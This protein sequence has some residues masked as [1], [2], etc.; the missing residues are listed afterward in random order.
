MT[1]EMLFN[2][3]I[4][5]SAAGVVLSN[6]RGDIT[7]IE[8]KASSATTQKKA[9]QLSIPFETAKVHEGGIQ[10]LFHDTVLGTMA[11]MVDDETVQRESGKFHLVTGKLHIFN[12]TP[13]LTVGRIFVLFRGDP[14]CQL[15]PTTTDETTNPQWMNPEE[16]LSSGHPIRPFA[17]QLLEHLIHEDTLEQVMTLP[18]HPLFPRGFSIERFYE[19]RERHP[20]L[21]IS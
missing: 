14:D 4:K 15:T 17:R 16:L 3:G 7:I 21:R 9:G 13:T 20:D 2:P 12:V 18:T 5:T 10:E 8:E 19:Q 1:P 6:L 11:E